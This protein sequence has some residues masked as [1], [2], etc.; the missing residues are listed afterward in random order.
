[1]TRASRCGTRVPAVLV[2][3]ALER[4]GLAPPLEEWR[5]ALGQREAKR[6]G[7]LAV[8][9]PAPTPTSA[10]VVGAADRP[11]QLPELPP[12]LV[13]ADGDVQ[14]ALLLPQVVYALLSTGQVLPRLL[15]QTD[16]LGE[17]CLQEPRFFA[18]E[19][20]G[21]SLRARVQVRRLCT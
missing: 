12:R 15:Q 9:L 3:S 14:V 7:R 10:L 13:P 19:I 16:V 6:F 5:L 11:F 20:A 8:L 2:G 18:G 1:M 17:R 21:H 4:F